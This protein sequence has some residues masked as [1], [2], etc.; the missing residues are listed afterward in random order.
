[1]LKLRN[2]LYSLI[3]FRF[4]LATVILII[5]TTVFGLA[6]TQVY[7]LISAI[8]ILTIIYSLIALVN[9][10]EASSVY[11]VRWDQNDD[12]INELKKNL[13]K[14]ILQLKVKIMKLK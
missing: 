8:Y 9:R 5:N 13:F 4:A 3:F 12:L 11:Q 7:F 1:M 6:H 14:V 10:K 2:S